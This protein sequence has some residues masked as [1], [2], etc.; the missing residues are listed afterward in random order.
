MKNA[1]LKNLFS[2]CKTK[3]EKNNFINFV[4]ELNRFKGLLGF[5][6]FI[7]TVLLYQR[8]Y[9]GSFYIKDKKNENQND[10]FYSIDDFKDSILYT[11]KSEDFYAKE[12]KDSV[13]EK[14]FQKQIES[15]KSLGN[16]Y[17][18]KAKQ[19]SKST[20]IEEKYF[21]LINCRS[22]DLI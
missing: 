16:I 13:E 17:L 9:K 3:I 15:L 10:E 7:G 22:Q 12:F 2:T 4:Y 19:V 21:Y 1:F 6:T 8:F 14:N 5:G 11:D 20:A 18:R